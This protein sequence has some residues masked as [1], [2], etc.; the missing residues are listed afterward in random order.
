MMLQDQ[1][2][3]KTQMLSFTLISSFKRCQKC[4]NHSK[5]YDIIRIWLVITLISRTEIGNIY[6]LE[7]D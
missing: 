3:K 5:E 1:K 4:Q 6:T 2:E 7:P